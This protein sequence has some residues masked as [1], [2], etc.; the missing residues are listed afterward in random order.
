MTTWNKNGQVTQT[1]GKPTQKIFL[2]MAGFRQ[3]VSS[4]FGDIDPERTA[5]RHIQ[6]LKQ[7]GLASAYTANFQ[8]CAGQTDWNDEALT[9]QYYKGLKDE[10]KD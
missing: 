4:V 2:G 6:N 10:V 5:E 9:A 8:Q 7:Q 3:Q 1:P